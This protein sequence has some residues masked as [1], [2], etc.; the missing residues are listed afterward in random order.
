[1]SK[2]A[3]RSL[4]SIIVLT[5]LFSCENEYS[6]VG[7][8]FINSIEVQ[9]PY[10]SENV[11]AY[12]EKHNAI[13][14]NGFR[15][16]FIG[17]Y[18]DPVFG[19]SET[20]LLTQVGLVQTNPDFGTNPVI[21]SVVMTL[22]FYSRQV[23]ENEYELDSVYGSGSF[24]LNVYQSNQF[25]RDLNPGPDGDF[26]E[27]QLYYTNQLDEFSPNIESEPIVTS[28]VIKPTD[29]TDPVV[30]VETT[31]DGGLDTLNLSPRIR[32]KMPT[33]YFQEKII[34]APNNEV[35]SSNSA[36]RN[37]LRGFLLEAEQQQPVL[38]MSMFNFQNTDANIT[39]YYRNE[40]EEEN[41]EGETTVETRYNKFTL[42]F[43][44]IK[45][46]LYENDFNV[47]LSSQDTIQG[48]ENIYLKGG[49]GSSGVIELFSGP[50]TDGNGF[51][52]ELDELRSNNWLINEANLDLYINE[53]VAPNSKN[54]IGRVFL[55]NLDDE[56]VLEDYLRDPTASDN[57]NLS[58]QVHL[59]PLSEDD[60]GDLFYRIRLT[61]HINNVINN[62]S[63]N[64]RLGLYV[65]E[66]VNELSLV[67]TKNPQL[68]IS[69]N[70]LR[71]M[72]ETPRGIVIHGNQSA[73][74]SKKLKLRIIYTETN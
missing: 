69:E 36:F 23:E 19:L 1:M 57:P 39:I 40:V 18:S 30:L 42:S 33:Q 49:E 53:E 72:M 68:G 6:E 5:F 2:F 20:K 55:F 43:N 73:T 50:D 48:E 64:V 10:E 26:Q 15:N 8:D 63:T 51:S 27:R 45:L 70:V 32:I 25:L 38:S 12:S 3:I 65:S 71:G 21:D 13:Q 22:P 66:N 59:G 11:I 62:D 47:D 7:T 17:H 37:Y 31:F 46:N 60:N 54:R 9:P 44:G 16:Y 74:E 34:N 4:A 29:L 61:S 41:T 28:E 67:K 14:T 52:D 58:R 24:K 56:E 35:L